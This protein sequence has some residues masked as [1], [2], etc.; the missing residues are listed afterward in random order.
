MGLSLIL[1]S[2]VGHVHY[3][4]LAAGKTD[5]RKSP[6][7]VKTAASAFADSQPLNLRFAINAAK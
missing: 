1:K 5:Q 4:S 3:K 6:N 7:V 2:V